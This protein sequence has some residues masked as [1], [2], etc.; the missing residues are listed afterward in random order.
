MHRLQNAVKPFIFRVQCK[1]W[2]FS[3]TW[4][5]TLSPLLGDV[6]C[7][8]RVTTHAARSI[9]PAWGRGGTL[10]VL[11]QLLVNS[12]KDLCSQ[13]RHITRAASSC[14]PFCVLGLVSKIF[15]VEKLVD[16]AIQCAEK[17]ASNSK[18]ITAMA[19][20]SVNAGRAVPGEGEAARTCAASAVWL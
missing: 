3:E 8:S 2:G 16:E 1:Q 5:R 14:S 4:Q 12:P 6:V 19:K 11:L 9:A 18:I 13:C 15:P 10:P 20:E 7:Q 17:I